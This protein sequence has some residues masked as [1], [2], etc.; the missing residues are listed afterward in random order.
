MVSWTARDPAVTGLAPAKSSGYGFG[1]VLHDL[2]QSTNKAATGARLL[3]VFPGVK[4]KGLSPPL[5][6]LAL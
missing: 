5:E 4:R 3:G 6:P 1:S 2:A